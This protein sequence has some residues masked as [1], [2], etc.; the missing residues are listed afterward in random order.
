MIV[1]YRHMTTVNRLPWDRFSLSFLFYPPHAQIWTLSFTWLIM[2]FFSLYI[3]MYVCWLVFLRVV[4]NHL[5]LIFIGIIG[6]WVPI[7]VVVVFV[8]VVVVVVA[9]RPVIYLV[10]GKITVL[11]TAF[12]R[13]QERRKK[14]KKKGFS[15]LLP[16]CVTHIHTQSSK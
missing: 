10:T 12:C 14:K 8:V 7:T 13:H 5:H 16:F 3:C 2:F 1:V 4:Y 11:G 15:G 9:P 6:T